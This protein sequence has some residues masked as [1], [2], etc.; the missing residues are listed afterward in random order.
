MNIN[1]VSNSYEDTLRTMRTGKTESGPFGSL[2]R[3]IGFNGHGNVLPSS[4]AK[5][6]GGSVGGESSVLSWPPWAAASTSQPNPWYDTFGLTMVQR[7]SAFAMCLLGAVLLFLLAFM[8]FPLV[9]LR[10]GKFVVPYCL[11]NMMLFASFG[12]VHGF[13]SYFR[14]LFSE[15][16]W[17]Y[18]TA[19]LGTTLLTLYVSMIMKM[20]A[21]T[22]PMAIIQFLAMIA[23]VVSYIP[24]GSGGI[25]VFRSLA[26]NSIRSSIGL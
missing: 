5:L 7:Y 1:S 8:H 24:G 19:F 9:I 23:Y 3:Y 26:A 15:N 18:S 16:R 11:G 12:F 25:S 6:S 22:I 13:Y 14:H 4:S 10:P 20:Y 17:P 2:K 21:L